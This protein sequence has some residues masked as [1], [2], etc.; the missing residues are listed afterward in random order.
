MKPLDDGYEDI[1]TLSIR[2][3]QD[4]LTP[5]ESEQFETYLMAHPEVVERLEIDSVFVTHLATAK[6]HLKD[7]K[8]ALNVLNSW[9]STPLRASFATFAVCTLIY[10]TAFVN[11]PAERG[12]ENDNTDYARDWRHPSTVMLSMTRGL[13][14]TTE[15]SVALDKDST[16]LLVFLQDEF[17]KRAEYNVNVL[18]ANGTQVYRA[19]G[20]SLSS[21]GDILLPIRA[22][23]LEQGDLTIEYAN[24]ETPGVIRRLT[25]SIEK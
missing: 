24:K 20:V 8:S 22:D 9:L 2:Y 14:D 17:G 10:S 23:K 13:D 21:D 25:L 5:E 1:Q 19:D 16:M 4:K 3:L 18:D 11:W 6:A 12:T 15:T 7:R